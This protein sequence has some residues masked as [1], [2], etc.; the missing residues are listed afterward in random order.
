MTTGRCS[1]CIAVPMQLDRTTALGVAKEVLAGMV[2]L[3]EVAMWDEQTVTAFTPTPLLG[4]GWAPQQLSIVV[5]PV[6]EG[7]TRLTCCSRPRYATAL[8]D[9]GRSVKTAT[10]L[11]RRTTLACHGR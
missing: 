5:E 1:T 4:L 8:N 2:G 3:S 7:A 9:A 11:A 10:E 6:A